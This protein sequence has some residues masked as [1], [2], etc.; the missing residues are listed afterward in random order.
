MAR[1]ARVV[2]PGAA[3]QVTQRG[4]RGQK[5]FFGDQ[6]YQAYLD[7]MAQWCA[8][9]GMEILAYCLMPNH[10][11]LIL[12]PPTEDALCRAIGEAHRRYTRAVNTR[13]GWRGHLWQDRFASFVM[14]EPYLL[15]A[16]KCIERSPV[17]A[18]LVKRAEDWPWSSAAAH[19]DR[20]RSSIASG[21][22]LTDSTADWVCTWRQ[23]LAEADEAPVAA[24]MRRS[25]STGRPLG[26]AAFIAKVEKL[27]GRTLARRK[28]GPKPG[29]KR[30]R[31][32]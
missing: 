20:R 2:V 16:A 5:T 7:L 21:D 13:K 26:D 19:V 23:Y 14:D 24:A 10:A 22:W 27:L 11:H 9:H 28:P 6:D 8:H 29:T 17:K 4:N 31:A 1:I 32:G 15:A 25:E 3:H 30:K 12:R 18:R